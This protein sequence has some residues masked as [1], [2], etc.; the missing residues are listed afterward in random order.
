MAAEDTDDRSAALLEVMG[1]AGS[2]GDAARVTSLTQL[3][4]GFSRHSWVARIQDPDQPGAGERAYVVRV[5]PHGSVLETSIEQ[6][7]RTYEV[8]VDEPVPTP[9]VHGFEPVDSPF[10][11]PFFVMDMLPGKAVNVWRRRDRELLEG[12]WNGD[13]GLAEDF[14]SY[15]AA[16]HAVGA[17]RLDGL[18]EART[19]RQTVEHW[20]GIWESVRLLRDPIIDEAYAW[21]L[22]REPPPV[23][24]CLVHSDYRIGNCL[25]EGGRLT[26]ILDWELSFVG[27]PRFDLG[28]MSL[29]YHAGKFTTP[30]SELVG[31]VAEPD[32]FYARYEELTGQPVDR[33]AVRTFA[34]LGGLMLFAIMSTGIKVYD[35]G[36]ST[37]IRMVWARFTFPGI[38]QD[39]AGL[40]GWRDPTGNS[41]SGR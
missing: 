9:G 22:D 35:S 38:R 28:Y 24:P 25:L 10:G 7:F 4:G 2:L 37:D 20:Q 3:E 27:D 11:G 5:K 1:G 41:A 31:A 36:R 16:I 33:E 39:L 34:A 23:E 30:G 6:E 14:V 32:W 29:E 13:R 12:D 8:L 15:L 26:G 40:M 18:V 21:V 17:D 19:F